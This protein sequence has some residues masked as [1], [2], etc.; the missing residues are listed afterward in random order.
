M[1]TYMLS[2]S[3]AEIN[4]GSGFTHCQCSAMHQSTFSTSVV[5]HCGCLGSVVLHCICL[6]SVAYHCAASNLVVHCRYFLTSVVNH[7]I[8]S[9]HRDHCCVVQVYRS[10]YDL[11]TL[12]PGLQCH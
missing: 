9:S 4:E 1:Q 8:L 10:L 2:C 6:G 3:E 12:L 5:L 7:C 11:E